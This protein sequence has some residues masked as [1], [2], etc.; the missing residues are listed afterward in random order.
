[1]HQHSPLFSPVKP[2]QL[3]ARDHKR[4]E[5]TRKVEEINKDYGLSKNRR[6]LLEI[7]RESEEWYGHVRT[8]IECGACLFSCP[9]CHCF[10]LYDQEGDT[11]EFQRVKEW[12][13]C[14]YA[15]YSKM[16]GGGSPRFGLMERFRHRYLHKFEYYPKNFGFEACTG[17]GRCVEG[18]MGNIDMRKTFKA[19]D[20]ITVGGPLRP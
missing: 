14:V 11:A 3:T 2:E 7:Q 8:C 13:A 18:C 1:M 17:C 20:K 12:D 5:T 9:T 15:G 16:A 4:A 6:E 19:L 10:L